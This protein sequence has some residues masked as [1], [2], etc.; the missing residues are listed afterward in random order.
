MFSIINSYKYRIVQTGDYMCHIQRK[1]FKTW[2]IWSTMPDTVSMTIKQAQA[3]IKDLEDWDRYL[4][5]NV[6]FEPI[7]IYQT[8]Y[9]KRRE[10]NETC[11][12]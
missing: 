6:K 12:Y 3:F 8:D 9:L 7:V 10:E 11:L 4:K 5:T 2:F 1:G